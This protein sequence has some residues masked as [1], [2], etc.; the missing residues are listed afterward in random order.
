[1]PGTLAPVL[2]LQLRIGGLRQF[3]QPGATVATI[4]PMIDVILADAAA[5]DARK[6]M[7]KP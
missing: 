3:E 4:G 1:V 5:K 6:V 7:R 2:T